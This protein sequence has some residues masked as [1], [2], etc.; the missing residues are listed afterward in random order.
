MFLLLVL[1]LS[2]ALVHYNPPFF[3][4]KTVTAMAVPAIPTYMYVW[5]RPGWCKPMKNPQPFVLK[6]HG[7]LQLFA[8]LLLSWQYWQA[9]LM[10]LLAT[11][12]L[13]RTGRFFQI[14]NTVPTL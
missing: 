2:S 14:C 3:L 13:K 7:M 1:N 11:P 5:C 8:S 10:V 12:V 4:L 9:L 6:Y